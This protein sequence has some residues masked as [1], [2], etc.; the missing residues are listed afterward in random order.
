[1]MPDLR[2]IAKLT[3]RH[4][5]VGVLNMRKLLS[6]SLLLLVLAGCE[7]GESPFK[8]SAAAPKT[9]AGSNA[10]GSGA[11][12]TPQKLLQLGDFSL[13]TGAKLDDANTLIVGTDERWVGRIVLRTTQSSVDTYNHF[14]NSMSRSG[15]E[16]VTALQ[17]KTSGLTYT[18]GERVATVMIEASTLSGTLVTILV[19]PRERSN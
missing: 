1:M 16:L 15:W 12:A 19:T 4:H 14:Y 8:R 7:A 9:V 10:V 2:I 3:C 13:P 18:R 17:G 6:T 5:G 11:R